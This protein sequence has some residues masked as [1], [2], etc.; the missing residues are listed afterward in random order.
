[1]ASDHVRNNE[2]ET[3]QGRMETVPCDLCRSDQSDLFI[4]QRDLLLAVT[5]EEFTIVRC[6]Q[7]PHTYV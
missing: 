4:R 7:C 6:R 1:M 3:T 5:D 2:R